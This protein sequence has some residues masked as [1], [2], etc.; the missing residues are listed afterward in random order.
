[1]MKRTSTL[2][3]SLLKK[4][5]FKFYVMPKVGQFLQLL[6]VVSGFIHKP[7]GLIFGHF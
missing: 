1:M 6:S 3:Q 2:R 5:Q 7:C 4:N